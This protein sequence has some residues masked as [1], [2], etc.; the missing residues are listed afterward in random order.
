MTAVNG[1]AESIICSSRVGSLFS[2]F[3]PLSSLCV[4]RDSW[5]SGEH[6]PPAWRN[7]RRDCCAPRAHDPG[8]WYPPPEVTGRRWTNG[9]LSAPEERPR[10]ISLFISP[11][12]ILSILSFPYQQTHSLSFLPYF[13]PPPT[14]FYS[15]LSVY[16]FK[17]RLND[18]FQMHVGWVLKAVTNPGRENYMIC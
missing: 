8:Q 10:L 14:S 11:S 12:I 9:R 17:R 1:R 13:C 16:T 7:S 4:E 5:G 2:F 3:F 15:L 18:F 6:R